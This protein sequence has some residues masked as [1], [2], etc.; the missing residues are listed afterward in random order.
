MSYNSLK[1]KL[2]DYQR[3]FNKL[4]QEE[5]DFFIDLFEEIDNIGKSKKTKGKNT[6]G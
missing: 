6:R 2:E 1:E 5:K 4:P 3:K